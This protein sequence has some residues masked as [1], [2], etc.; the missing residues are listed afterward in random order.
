[1]SV[2]TTSS[3]SRITTR[4]DAGFRAVVRF[5]AVPL[6]ATALMA[7]CAHISVVLPFSAVPVTMQTFAVLLIA[8]VLGPTS[9]AIAMLLYLAEGVAG[10]SVFSPHGAG[11]LAQ[12]AGPSGG[13]LLSYPVAAFLAGWSYKVAR[14]RGLPAILSALSGAVA[15]E[16]TIFTLGLAWLVTAFQLSPRVALAGGVLPFL[17]GELIK[18]T[19]ALLFVGGLERAKRAR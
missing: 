3:P 1:M 14:R 2:L 13:Y 10:L 5:G 11:G 15:S 18:M 8:V 7:V 4:N 16:I 9:A 17:P 6:A 12:I 19:L